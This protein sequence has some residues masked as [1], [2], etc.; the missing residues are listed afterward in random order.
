MNGGGDAGIG[1]VN[2]AVLCVKN[3]RVLWAGPACELESQVSVSN[4][5]EFVSAGGCVVTPALLILT[6]TQFLEQ[7]ARKSLQCGPQEQITETLQLPVV[8]YLTA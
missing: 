1:I 2:D 7:H 3:G 8:E 6:R 5:T 4:G